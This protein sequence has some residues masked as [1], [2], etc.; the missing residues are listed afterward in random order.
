MQ[1]PKRDEQRQTD[2]IAGLGEG[3]QQAGGAVG[4][5]EGAGDRVQQRLRVV[6]VRDCGAAGEREQHD[7]R[8]ADA[9]AQ[10]GW[11]SV[12]IAHE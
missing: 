10:L 3:D 1:I 5:R 4:H 8:P 11:L 7:E 12:A 6:Q 9:G 2:D